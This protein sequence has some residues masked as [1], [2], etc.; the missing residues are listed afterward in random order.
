[1]GARARTH[2]RAC[3][4]GLLDSIQRRTVD[5]DKLRATLESLPSA[6]SAAASV[7]D[8]AA[9]AVDAFTRL[10]AIASSTP[11]SP[12]ESEIKGLLTRQPLL[13]GPTATLNA[14]L[15]PSAWSVTLDTGVVKWYAR[16]W[17]ARAG[18]P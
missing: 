16:G 5:I 9:D 18:V 6:V 8:V 14:L 4:Q 13:L 11:S 3:V 2:T 7:K 15:S 12:L 10:A 1:M 17:L